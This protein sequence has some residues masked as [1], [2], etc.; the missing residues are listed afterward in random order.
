MGE[1]AGNPERRGNSHLDNPRTEDPE[2]IIE[3]IEAG[4]K[5]AGVLRQAYRPAGSYFFHAIEEAR[6]GDVVR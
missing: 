4:L 1:L 6:E 3:D 2:A 5:K